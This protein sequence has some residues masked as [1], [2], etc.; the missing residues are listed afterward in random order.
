MWALLPLLFSYMVP[1]C[2]W[3]C[4][5]TLILDKNVHVFPQ[6][7]WLFR[8]GIYIL[9]NCFDWPRVDDGNGQNINLGGLRIWKCF[10]RFRNNFAIHL[11]SPFCWLWKWNTPCKSVLLT[12]EMNTP[13]TS[14]LLAVERDT[15]CMSFC[16]GGGH[17]REISNAG[18]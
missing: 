4:V 1:W 17:E 3:Q 14:K 8:Y 6:I 11:A 5:A 9:G 12:V 16:W 13:S 7:V 2:I 15:S 10:S 18:R